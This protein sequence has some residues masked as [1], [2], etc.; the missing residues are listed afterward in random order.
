MRFI[1]LYLVGYFIL[2]IGMGL[3]LSH[4]AVFARVSPIWIVSGGLVAVGLGILMSVSSGKP[5]I[6]EEIEK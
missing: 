3:A 6:S 5:M 1:R 2:V 4:L